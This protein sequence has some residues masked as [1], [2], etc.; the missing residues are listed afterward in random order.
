M[1]LVNS[2]KETIFIL[3]FDIEPMFSI[4]H[5]T[6]NCPNNYEYQLQRSLD[7][8]LMIIIERK[9]RATFFIVGWIAEKYPKLVKQ[10][11]DLGFE[12]GVHSFYHKNI[13]SMNKTDFKEDL[14]KSLGA[15]N[16]VIGRQVEIFR[17]PNFS[18]N[19]RCSWIFKEL[20]KNGIRI[21]SSIVPFRFLQGGY[22]D[23]PSYE[24]CLLKYNE[25]TIKE[26]PIT[27]IKLPKFS[28][29]TG[30]GYFRLFPYFIFKSLSKH[31]KYLM[32]YFHPYDF[33]RDLHMINDI[34]FLDFIR[35]KVGTN[36]CEKKLKKWLN[37]FRFTDISTANAQI[38][39]ENV[40]QIH[41]D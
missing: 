15:I 26:L 34:S 9:L 8:I 27:G 37:E 23:F 39:W 21:D 1:K 18:I 14:K 25:I 40:S 5:K 2:Q 41:L 24:P 11:N 30:G 13:Y 10:I 36:Q 22:S 35:K 16:S 19:D 32:N 12:I 31:R 29:L 7:N 28:I 20:Y 38:P 6:N 17:A 33:D 3:T 4:S